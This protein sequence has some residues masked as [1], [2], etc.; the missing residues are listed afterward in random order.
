MRRRRSSSVKMTDSDS[1]EAERAWN[2]G[3][4]ISF[5]LRLTVLRYPL[6]ESHCI[7]SQRLIISFSHRSR[8]QPPYPPFRTI[9][10]HPRQTYCT[11]TDLPPFSS[12]IHN[13]S[14]R[15]CDDLRYNALLTR[16]NFH[17]HSLAATRNQLPPKDPVSSLPDG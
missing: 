6:Q 7:L 12:Q 3:G 13:P 16:T 1:A 11:R 2:R 4:S 5:T 15:R 9:S 8:G 17:H 14:T 10:S